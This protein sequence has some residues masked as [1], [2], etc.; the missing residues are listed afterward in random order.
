MPVLLSVLAVL[1]LAGCGAQDG[2]AAPTRTPPPETSAAA[3]VTVTRTGGLAGVNQSIALS[4]DGSWVYT[5]GRRNQTERGTLTDAQR[6][7]VLQLLA[8]PAFAQALSGR[9]TTTAVCNDGFE[10]TISY[11]SARFAFTDCGQ[12]DAPVE[13]VLA[14]LTD[15]TPF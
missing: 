8:S 10:Y 4:P 6:A 3:P 15:A 13:A 5:D 1:V 11:G 7:Q 14:A 2:G 9:A 12:A